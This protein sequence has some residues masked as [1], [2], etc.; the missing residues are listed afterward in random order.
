MPVKVYPGLQS[1][2]TSYPKLPLRVLITQISS[3]CRGR[4]THYP[5]VVI[6]QAAIGK[7][8]PFTDMDSRLFVGLSV[9]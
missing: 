4:R 3:L 2:G 6:P 8:T 5:S 7:I 9:N 1:N